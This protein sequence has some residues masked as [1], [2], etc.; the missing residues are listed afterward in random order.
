[1]KKREK[2]WSH[3]ACFDLIL[4]LALALILLMLRSIHAY[5]TEICIHSY[6]PHRTRSNMSLDLIPQNLYTLLYICLITVYGGLMGPTDI[7]LHWT[8]FSTILKPKLYIFCLFVIVGVFFCCWTCSSKGLGH[9][10]CQTR[11]IL[12]AVRLYYVWLP[13]PEAFRI[14]SL[15][16]HVR[17]GTSVTSRLWSLSV[18]VPM[19]LHFM[20]VNS[21]TVVLWC[22]VQKV[23]N[24]VNV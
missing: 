16:C 18:T 12:T 20:N 15:L 1:M 13:L 3:Y 11:L 5:S 17:S 4:I 24:S 8:S 22:S 23:E 7:D 2:Y 19:Y 14:K 21:L 9:A 6:M 10:S